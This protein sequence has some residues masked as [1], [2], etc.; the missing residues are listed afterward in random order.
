MLPDGGPDPTLKIV[1]D[2]L[3]AAPDYAVIG[4]A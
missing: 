3:S 4:S 1:R 2:L